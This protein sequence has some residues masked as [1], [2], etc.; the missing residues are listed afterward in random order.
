MS[1]SAGAGP[2]PVLM[3]GG[4][5]ARARV[6]A[7][8]NGRV[9]H[10][11]GLDDACAAAREHGPAVILVHS[12][13]PGAQGAGP[14]RALRQAAPGAALLVLPDQGGEAALAAVGAA[15]RGD[16]GGEAS[17]R[18]LFEQ[19][20]DAVFLTAPDGG[21]LAANPAACR[22]FGYAEAELRALGRAAVVDPDDPRLAAALE[23]R[24]RTGRFQG[25][26]T[27]VRKDGSR[28]PVEVSTQVFRDGSGAERTSL[29]VRD[30]TERK[31]AEE[32]LAASERKYRGLVQGL[33]DGVFLCDAQNRVLEATERMHE[34]LGQ[35]P[36]A[37]LGTR[38]ADMVEAEDLAATPLRRE[39]LA[40][41]GMLLSTRMVRR[42]D[43]SVFPAEVA[44][45][46]LGDGRVEC[47][48]RDITE[49]RRAERER[50]LL[51]SAGEVF[52]SS[53]EPHEMLRRIAR[54]AVPAHAD[55]CIIDV[56]SE[57]GTLEAAESAAADPRKHELLRALL[58][59]YPHSD[60]AERHPVGRVLQSGEPVLVPATDPAALRPVAADAE[61]QR[62]IDQ[63]DPR[64]FLV[65]PLVA[66]GRILGA[67][68][69]AASESG[70][71]FGARDVEIAADLA[72]R[73]A[74]E[75]EKG[76]LVERLRHAVQ[77]RDQV[78]A[79]VAHDLRSPLGGIGLLAE[80]LIRV[81]G[82][83]EERRRSLDAIL[84]AA[85]QIDRLIQDLLDAS[86]LQA[87][88]LRLHPAA[89]AVGPV[90]RES[91]LVLGPA[92]AQ[93]GVEL[94]LD[95]PERVPSV[96]AD[97]DRLLQVLSN[98]LGNAIKFTPP[99]GT[100][101]LGVRPA[102]GAM[103][104]SVADT[105]RG[106]E[107]ADLPRL[108]DRF[109]QAE[110]TRE[111]GA[112]LGLAIAKGLVEA[113]GGRIWAGSRPGRGSTFWFTLPLAGAPPLP[114]PGLAVPAP[115]S[116]PPG[117]AAA[118][119]PAPAPAPAQGASGE[120]LRVLLVDDHPTLRRGLREMLSAMEEVEV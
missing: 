90:V 31:R 85:R 39:E 116:A 25:E 53:L 79:Y 23:E 110:R 8:G 80:M 89:E 58:E 9:V 44:S 47:V 99:G 35:P 109:W 24:R 6:L 52:A 78:L 55:W 73:T 69:L 11:A 119:A 106:I 120:R 32:A 41:G 95:V 60:S 66:R 49:R 81:P 93:A 26:L 28:I 17:F 40:R 111:G 100:I 2:G 87:G 46:L 57:D 72:R 54:L 96:L 16:E 88:R 5:P 65:V 48:V 97:R 21:V 118:S 62:L 74:L 61:H 83:E 10:A 15:L 42:R 113:H 104:F 4:D 30:V 112:G 86:R 107:A 115:G 45:V 92:A 63:L 64:S 114:A 29:F 50:E 75:V 51:V 20:L 94:R 103:V 27:F 1:D 70:R 12:S 33:H 71:V 105:G 37:L 101:T 19:S 67:V 7:S 22:M 117:A 59:R 3:V 13:L 18:A 91:V 14:L 84:Q 43:G 38:V 108:F 102:E 76:R 98:L 36:G 68:T 56:L 77:T 82:T 34:M